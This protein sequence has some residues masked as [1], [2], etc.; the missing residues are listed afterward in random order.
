MDR[1][2]ISFSLI[3]YNQQSFIREALEGAFAQTYSPLEIVVVDDCSPDR[4]F[5]IIR[6]MAD[7]YHGPHSLRIFQNQ[8]NLG[9]AGNFHRASELCRGEFVVSAAGDDV[10]LPMRT[11]LIYRIWEESARRA[12]G[13]FSS[14]I[15][16]AADG[17]EEGVAGTRDIAGGSSLTSRMVGDLFRFLSTRDPMVNGCSAA[18]S[19]RLWRYFGP[20]R[21]DLEDVVL[22]FRTL[23]IGELYYIS[24]PLLKYRRHQDNVSWFSGERFRS[25]ESRE[26]RLHW[27]N[28]ATV[29]TY[30]NLLLDIETLF[31]KGDI[32]S[33]DR[34]RLRAEAL[35]VQR[36]YCLE[37]RM[38]DGTATLRLRTVAEG[39]Q[40]HQSSRSEEH[41]SE[42]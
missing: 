10:S 39:S 4:T 8:A 29:R 19:P 32:A 9:L 30:D 12:T 21:G 3:C 16:I 36:P 7:A 42:L 27:R 15:N 34:D 26:E 5:N 38:I 25:F 6:E 37:N 1:P 40:S 18:W 23:A 41:T 33:G 11:E 22:S 14:H 20:V 13:I 35:R 31:Q 28:R 24:Q 2:L 17:T